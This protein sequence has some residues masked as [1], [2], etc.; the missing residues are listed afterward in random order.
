MVLL[1]FYRGRCTHY[2]DRLHDFSVTIPRYYKMS[3]STGSFLAQLDSGILCLY[4]AFNAAYTYDLLM[5]LSRELTDI[6]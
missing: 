1:L 6:F 5:A 2:S 4:N 3:M